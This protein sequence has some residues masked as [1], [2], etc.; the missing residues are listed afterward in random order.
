M[1][2]FEPLYRAAVERQ[3]LGPLLLDS[4]AHV[5]MAFETLPADLRNAAPT[6]ALRARLE[7]WTAAPAAGGARAQSGPLARLTDRELEVLGAVAGG[8]GNKQIARNLDLSL[9]TVKRH[10]ANILD[11]LDCASRG[12]AADLY[13]RAAS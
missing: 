3:D 5:L 1:A 6:Q 13:K 7:A 8:A 4:R 11:K 9:H 12:Q 10:I 2:A